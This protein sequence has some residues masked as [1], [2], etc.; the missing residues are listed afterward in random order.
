MTWRTPAGVGS[1]IVTSVRVPQVGHGVE[2]EAR[3]GPP[4]DDGQGHALRGDGVADEVE[5]AHV[6]A[7]DD[8]PLPALVGAR[9]RR[10][11]PSTE[12][13][14]TSP[15]WLGLRWRSRSS[16][17]KL[18]AD[19]RKTCRAIA[20]SCACGVSWSQHLAVIGDDVGPVDGSQPDPDVADK[21]GDAIPQPVRQP[22]R[23]ARNDV[24]AADRQRV[25]ELA[26]LLFAGSGR[27]GGGRCGPVSSTAAGARCRQR[28]CPARCH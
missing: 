9:G 22:G 3:G 25:A 24:G 1:T 14:P 13:A 23:D 6:R 11:G 17:P 8:D 2:D 28:C 16:S 5:G 19:M 4:G 27:W 7:G 10:R 18:R 21:I 12:M 26:R 20:S 15:I